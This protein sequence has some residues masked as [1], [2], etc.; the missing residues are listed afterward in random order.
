M[1]RAK[2]VNHPL[3]RAPRAGERETRYRENP[4]CGQTRAKGEIVHEP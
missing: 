3:I 4:R 1:E 2:P